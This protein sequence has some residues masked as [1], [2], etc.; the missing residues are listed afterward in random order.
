ME[1][2]LAYCVTRVTT[3]YSYDIILRQKC[4]HNT[5]VCMLEDARIHLYQHL[6]MRA[7]HRDQA[8]WRQLIWL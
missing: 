7:V 3:S 6:V 4:M 2:F 8:K 1:L 5:L